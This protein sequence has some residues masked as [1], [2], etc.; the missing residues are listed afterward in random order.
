MIS[1]IKKWSSA[2]NK[3]LS[4]QHGAKQPLFYLPNFRRAGECVTLT[5]S[6]SGRSH[7]HWSM[8]FNLAGVGTGAEQMQARWALS[9][10]CFEQVRKKNSGVNMACKFVIIFRH[11]H[12]GGKAEACDEEVVAT[13]GYGIKISEGKSYDLGA[14]EVSFYK[15]NKPVLVSYLV[16]GFKDGGLVMIMP[17]PREGIPETLVCATV[18]INLR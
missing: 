16:G 11:I 4:Q 10:H 7:S 14:K 13:N 9:N 2:H 12:G 17:R 18:P 6:N 8:V 3:L 15:A 5:G 1:F